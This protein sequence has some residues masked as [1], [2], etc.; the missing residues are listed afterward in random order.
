MRKTIVAGVVLALAVAVVVL[1]SSALHLDLES[2]ALLGGALGA[3]V[4]LVPD[5]SPL[6]R[7]LGFAGGFVIV[8]ISY[9][10]RAAVLPDTA[11]GQAVAIGLVV[12]LCVA[13]TVATR[14]RLPMWS[15]LLGAAALTG[16]Y[17]YTYV[18]APPEMASTSLIAATALLFNVAIGFLVVALVAPSDQTG[19]TTAAPS[20]EPY[21]DEGSSAKLDDFMMEKSQ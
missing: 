2:A 10:L 4:A 1:L 13:L 3:V 7:L 16:A 18:A 20:S 12:L 14:G 11:A 9:A 19:R 17:E 8:W 5:R 6:G 21:D 15:T